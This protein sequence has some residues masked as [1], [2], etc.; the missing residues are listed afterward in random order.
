MD[1]A[2]LLKITLKERICPLGDIFFRVDPFS[3][4][5]CCAVKQTRSHKKLSPLA[6]MEETP[7]GVSSPL[8]LF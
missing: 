1:L 4:G 7:P 2:S 6:E 3:E 5:A 8:K